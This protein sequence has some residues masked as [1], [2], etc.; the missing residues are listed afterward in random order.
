MTGAIVGEEGLMDFIRCVLSGLRPWFEFWGSPILWGLVL[1][2]LGIL[3]AIAAATAESGVGEA[4][5]GV[6]AAV[7]MAFVV[8]AGFLFLRDQQN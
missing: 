7:A 2:I 1:I 6:V 4:L 3:L 8:T 5:L